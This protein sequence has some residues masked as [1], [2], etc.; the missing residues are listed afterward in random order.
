M[1]SVNPVIPT[2]DQIMALLGASPD[3]DNS[4]LPPVPQ[5]GPYGAPAV[6]ASPLAAALSGG[7]P[8][9]FPSQAPP[10]PSVV[11]PSPTAPQTTA[12]PPQDQQ[13]PDFLQMLADRLRGTAWSDGR[14]RVGPDGNFLPP[15][16]APQIQP[17]VAS[18]NALP[19]PTNVASTGGTSVPD[20]SD[21]D[22]YTAG[23]RTLHDQAMKHYN[24]MV[25]KGD[26]ALAAGNTDAA[27]IYFQQATQAGAAADQIN[28]KALEHAQPDTTNKITE[29]EYGLAHPGFNAPAVPPREVNDD[30]RK[31]WNLPPT[32]SFTIAPGEAPKPITG[33]GT[34]TEAS[35]APATIDDLAT[36]Y[37]AGD[38]QAVTILGYGSGANRA[39][40]LDRASELSRQAGADPTGQIANRIALAG[41]MQAARTTGALGAKIDQFGDSTMGALD[42]VQ[43]NSDAVPRGQWMPLNQLQQMGERLASNPQ[44]AAFNS[45][46][47]TAVNEYA[48]AT[49]MTG[50]QTDTAKDHAYRMLNQAQ[51]PQAMAAVLDNLRFEVRNLQNVSREH[52][53]L[54]PLPNNFGTQGAPPAGGAAPRVRVYDPATG[55]LK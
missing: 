4:D 27:K 5:T 40:I 1:V 43:K 37:L 52:R 7:M 28:M 49:T 9:S 17:A 3:D 38:P 8:G 31:I 16:Q 24:D 34:A 45:S 29:Y 15:Q 6:T 10:P 18:S 35:L 50:A 13:S 54:D 14:S 47:E 2:A 30:E 48:R 42:N 32:G 33:A 53:G 19:A 46:I 11:S 22:A 20:T 21:D 25:T 44:L 12:P 23:L 26:A 51:S 41:K 36:R 55:T 39:A